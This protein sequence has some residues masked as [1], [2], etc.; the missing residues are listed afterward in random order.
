[1]KVETKLNEKIE[2][3]IK[4]CTNKSAIEKFDTFIT[5]PAHLNL[6]AKCTSFLSRKTLLKQ[7]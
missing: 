2:K 4:D 3:D 7:D 5:F 1:M 6:E